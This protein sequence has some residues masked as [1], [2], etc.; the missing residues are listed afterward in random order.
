MRLILVL[1]SAV[2]AM[3]V[4]ASL[5]QQSSDSTW[6]TI[7]VV[8]MVPCGSLEGLAADRTGQTLAMWNDCG[9]SPRDGRVV[10]ATR[11]SGG[12]FGST[13]ELP[14][15]VIGMTPQGDGAALV[16]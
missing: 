15:V 1:L 14:G 7:G 5:A 9:E 2:G 16:A 3:L 8:Q 11:P 4:P 13:A 6:S 10:V 12:A